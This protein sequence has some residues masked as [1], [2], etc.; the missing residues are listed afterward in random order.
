M[1]F[2]AFS[3][4][5]AAA[6]FLGDRLR[7]RLGASA[8]VRGSAALAGTGLGLALLAGTPAAGVAGFACAGLGL[9]NIVPILFGGAGR[10]KGEEPGKAI[11][12]VTTTGYLGFLAGPPL[13]GLAA[14]ASTLGTALGL[15]VLACAVVA[16]AAHR[17]LGADAGPPRAPEPALDR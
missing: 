7:H 17:A 12:A 2:A 13:I 11:A 5:M 14:E 9:A 6:R 1:G 8:L 16:V 3:A 15:V 10:L 4:T